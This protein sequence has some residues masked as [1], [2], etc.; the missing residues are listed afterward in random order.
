LS[1]K[2]YTPIYTN[3]DLNAIQSIHALYR[4]LS[5]YTRGLLTAP[6]VDGYR[7]LFY[8]GGLPA[9]PSVDGEERR[10]NWWWQLGIGSPPESP[11]QGAMRGPFSLVV[12]LSTIKKRMTH[13]LFIIRDKAKT[14]KGTDSVI[15]PINGCTILF[16][17]IL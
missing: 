4:I 7:I 6:S 17:S 12:D 10:G 1:S 8:T 9:A 3:L 11:E 16:L 14:M 13:T 15:I 5:S 2:S